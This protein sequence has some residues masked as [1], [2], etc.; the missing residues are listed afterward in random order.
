MIHSSSL[1]AVFKVLTFSN[2]SKDP[3]DTRAK[4]RDGQTSSQLL[5]KS[6]GGTKGK[7][8]NSLR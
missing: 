1:L 8:D 7:L 3:R 6:A 4:S 5:Q 2:K